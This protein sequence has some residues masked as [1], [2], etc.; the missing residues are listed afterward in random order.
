MGGG[1]ASSETGTPLKRPFVLVIAEDDDDDF[2]LLQRALDEV[3]FGDRVWRARDGE[4]LMGWLRGGLTRGIPERLL[5]LLDLNMPRKNGREALREI[6]EHPA[7]RRMPVVVWTNS[8]AEEDILGSYDLGAN[9]YLRKPATYAA[10]IE[11]ALALKRHWL[12][13]ADLPWGNAPRVRFCRGAIV[14]GAE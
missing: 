1:E 11:A 5:L 12:D 2:Y 10:L 9:A 4:E 8:S 3:R 13:T 7:L 14:G 6:K